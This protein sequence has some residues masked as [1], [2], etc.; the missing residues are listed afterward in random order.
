[1]ISS[2][3]RRR[4]HPANLGAHVRLKVTLARS[5]GQNDDIVVTTDAAASVPTWPAPSPG[6][7]RAARAH[8]RLRAVRPDGHA[9]LHRHCAVGTGRAARV[10][11]HG[12]DTRRGRETGQSTDAGGERRPGDRPGVPSAS[13]A[14]RAKQPAPLR[15]RGLAARTV[16]G[17]GRRCS[18]WCC[19][20]WSRG[21]S[22]VRLV[23]MVPVVPFRFAASGC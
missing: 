15:L 18:R 21:R 14:A 1:M 5:N 9:I 10:S 3:A 8:A 4:A 17:W 11:R 19:R 12:H 2:S 7:I 20:W 6:S 16:G 13:R 23:G 22:G